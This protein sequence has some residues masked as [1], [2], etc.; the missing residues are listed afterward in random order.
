MN[1]KQILELTNQVQ[2][3]YAEVDSLYDKAH[4]TE[5]AIRKLE[6][7]LQMI[8]DEGDDESKAA[9]RGIYKQSDEE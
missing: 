6:S 3:L 9:I 7:I 8:W 5:K 4:R 1:A 2:A